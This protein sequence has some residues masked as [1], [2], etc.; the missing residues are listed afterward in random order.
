MT[1]RRAVSR[2]RR[3]VRNLT[4]TFRRSGLR[5]WQAAAIVNLYSLLILTPVY[6]LYFATD[7]LSA[8]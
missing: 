3:K 8:N 6:I 1:R 2:R 5:L 4:V 7:L